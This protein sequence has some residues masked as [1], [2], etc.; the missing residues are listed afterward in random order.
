M[1]SY[2]S[3]SFL[4]LK[5]ISSINRASSP[6]CLTSGGSE[7]VFCRVLALLARKQRGAEHGFASGPTSPWCC[8]ALPP[9]WT[10][11]MAPFPVSPEPLF[12]IQVMPPSSRLV[13]MLGTAALYKEH[14]VLVQTGRRK[15]S[16]LL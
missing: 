2:F 8:P 10:V 5:P 7:Q 11:P 1:S 4:N 14:H 3:R 16:P 15:G 6:T 9:G 13:G 12:K